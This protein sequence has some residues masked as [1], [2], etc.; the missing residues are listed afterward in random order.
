MSSAPHTDRPNATKVGWLDCA[1]GA[2]GDML[3]GALVDAG[4]PLQALQDAV[5]AVVPGQVVLRAESVTR[6]GLRALRVHVEVAEPAGQRAW[7]Q[8]RGLLKHAAGL[9]DATRAQAVATFASLADAEAQVH[10]IEPDDVHLRKR[11]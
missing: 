4:V 8:V 9:D 10:G 3:L 1:S 6:A 5:D 11:L 2:S 7:A